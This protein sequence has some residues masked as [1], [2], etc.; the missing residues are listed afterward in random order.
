MSQVRFVI[1]SQP[2]TGSTLLCSLLS[3]VPGVRSLVEPINP[4]THNHHMKP[5]KGSTCL[6]PEKMVQDNLLRA[7]NLLFSP[8]PLPEQ[9]VL[10]RKKANRAAGF[11]IMAHQ[12]Q[13]L[14]SEQIFWEYIVAEKIKV[15]LCF[16][17]NILMQHISD[18]ITQQTRQP[19]CWDGKIKTARIY[20]NPKDINPSLALIMKQKK[21]LIDTVANL[22]IEAKRIKY[23]DFK[24]NIKPVE[25]L[26]YWL[27]G[28]RS[29]LTTKLS[30]Q[31][32][33]N[34]ADRVLNYEEVVAEINRLGL[35][36]LLGE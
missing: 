29:P 17:Y 3:S 23:E 4:A 14:R 36:H 5:I 9:W 7:L 1:L 26:L 28:E 19:A 25:D 16:R 24:N 31:N 13:G 34:L 2:R 22:G 12:L 33:D 10:S 30:K 18:L 21:Y 20:L 11:K 32:S 8:N 27:I 15:I 35:S 6:L